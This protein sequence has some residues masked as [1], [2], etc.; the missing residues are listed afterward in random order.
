MQMLLLLA[1][2]GFHALASRQ[3]FASLAD[4]F[5]EVLARNQGI[6]SSCAVLSVYECVAAANM[7][8]QHSVKDFVNVFR[9]ERIRHT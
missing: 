9:T 1:S 3:P 4:C 6:R 8:Q 5:S 2:A 7:A